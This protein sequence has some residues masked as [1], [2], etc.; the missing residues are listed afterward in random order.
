MWLTLPVELDTRSNDID[1]LSELIFRLYD[2]IHKH[3]LNNDPVKAVKLTYRLE[4]KQEST[5]SK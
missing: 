2:V 5:W 3:I 1:D 4:I